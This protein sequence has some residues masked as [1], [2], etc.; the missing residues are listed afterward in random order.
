MTL[1]MIVGRKESM[2]IPIPRGTS[3]RKTK[4]DWSK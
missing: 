1:R 2:Q 3:K 4:W